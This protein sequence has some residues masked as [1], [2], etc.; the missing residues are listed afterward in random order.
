MTG[1]QIANVVL[2]FDLAELYFKEER[3]L[4]YIEKLC[5]EETKGEFVENKLGGLD[6]K[7][8]KL[9]QSKI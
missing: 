8:I 3:D 7:S 4:H 5:L 9:I 6:F 2:K 1:A